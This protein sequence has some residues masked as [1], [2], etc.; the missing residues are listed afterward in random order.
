MITERHPK[1]PVAPGGTVALGGSTGVPFRLHSNYSED[2]G[3]LLRFGVKQ[4]IL[5]AAEDRAQLF[6]V[7]PA[8]ALIGLGT[9]S[10]Q[11][12]YRCVALEL[13]IEFVEQTEAYGDPFFSMPTPQSLDQMA[14]MVEVKPQ[15][16]AGQLAETF[17]SKKINIAP[18]CRQLNALKTLVSNNP[19]LAARLRVTTPRANLQGLEGRCSETLLSTAVH[20]LRHKYPNLSAKIPVTVRQSLF[21]FVALQF[22]AALWFFASAPIGLWAHLV[23]TTFYLGCISL[24]LL[25]AIKLPAVRAKMKNIHYTRTPDH[26][27]PIYSVMVAL[28]RE[29]GQVDDLV[30]SL[31]GFDWPRERLEI[32]LVCEANDPET[33]AAVNRALLRPMANHISLVVVPNAHPQTKPKALNYSLPLCRGE[34]VVIYDAEDRPA[35]H[36]L[37]EAHF[38]F[39]NGP[40]ELACLQAP[41]VIHNHW[42]NWLSAMFCVEYSTLFDGLLP[43]LSDAGLPIPLGGTSNHFKR[44]VLV[45]IGGWDPYNVAE[46]ADL[47]IRLAR[48]GCKIA[49]ITLPTFEEAP[50]DFTVWMKQRTRWFKG[51]LQTWLVHM[52][53]PFVLAKNL[54]F[55]GTVIFH[56]LLSGM[57]VSALVHPLLLYLIGVY[58][59]VMFQQGFLTTVLHPIFL[60][61]IATV[62]LGYL[63]IALLAERTLKI[64]NIR[65]LRRAFWWIPVYWIFLSIAAWRAVWHLL[66]RPHEWEKTPHRMQAN[67]QQQASNNP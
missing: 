63:S 65:H 7:T 10:Q 60:L 22:L 45:K 44:A 34:Y 12:Y 15:V 19:D 24:R 52:R 51:W 53:Q 58:V 41:L 32:K 21:I 16:A 54:G 40:P 35:P 31:L 26:E 27:L 2:I 62:L 6:N 39:I 4:E 50:I 23:A 13:G 43:V 17:T 42:E 46:D 3:F 1:P 29:A 49:T 36:Q 61:D 11:D 8:V 67:R 37:R 9:L 25:A 38:T 28:Y 48:A 14:Q 57:V 64:R 55:G 47:G 33:H 5:N 66:T 18:D 20:G 30:S 59:F 56:L